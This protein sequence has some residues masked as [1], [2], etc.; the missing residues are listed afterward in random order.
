M[1]DTGMTRSDTAR[2]RVFPSDACGAGV[3]GDT[4]SDFTVDNGDRPLAA[5]QTPASPASGDITVNYDLLDPDSDPLDLI[6]EFSTDSGVTYQAAT[7]GAGSQGTVALTS[8]PTGVAHIYVW[9]SGTDV[10]ANLRPF[11]RLKIT[12]SDGLGPGQPGETADFVVDNTVAASRLYTLDIPVDP[13]GPDTISGYDIG[14][15]GALTAMA[16]SPWSTGGSGRQMSSGSDLV[17][18]PCGRFLFAS[19]SDSL[20]ISA[21]ELDA[22]GVPVP[23]PGSPFSTNPAQWLTALGLH[24]SGNFLYASLGNDQLD[25][26]SVDP[27]T[28][29]LTLLSGFPY[30]AGSSS[31]DMVVHPKGDFLYTGH[32]FGA[33]EGVRVHAIDP[34]TGAVSF[35]SWLDLTTWSGR[36]GSDM[37]IDPQGLRLFCGSLD[38]GVFVADIDAVSGALTLVPSAPHSMGGAYIGTLATTNRGDYL[39][40]HLS[41]N[42]ELY[43]YKIESNGSLTAVPGSP[44]TNTGGTSLYMAVD[45]PDQFLYVSSRSDNDIRIYEIQTDGSLV[46]QAS[47]PFAN[48]NPAGVPGPVLPYP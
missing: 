13:A 24:Q 41:F 33:D 28:G 8:S 48:P 18:S 12:P 35:S 7:E 36:P 20:D 46:E 19:H 5:L 26:F 27:V 43:G 38:A 17:V 1:A 47:S 34:V 42:V 22:S 44:Y 45:G 31:R 21:Y 9:E 30:T 32:M 16:G 25:G 14:G 3:P 2:F 6:V 15:G 11:T 39:Y 23:A 37:A 29:A 4:S 10:G 40:V